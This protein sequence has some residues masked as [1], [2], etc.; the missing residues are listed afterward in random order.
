M[1]GEKGGHT[2]SWQTV[3]VAN[4]V[5]RVQ[6]REARVR[7]RSVALRIVTLVAYSIGPPLIKQDFL[8]LKVS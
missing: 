3:S 8:A 6:P 4:G 1:E 7:T 5:Q 2:S